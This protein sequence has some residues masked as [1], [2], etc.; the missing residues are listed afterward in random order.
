MTAAAQITAGGSVHE[1]TVD[2]L[3]KNL[4]LTVKINDTTFGQVGKH[5]MLVGGPTPVL[6]R[7]VN[8]K[9]TTFSF[10]KADVEDTVEEYKKDKV[11][12]LTD[13][14]KYL[15]SYQDL[16][17]EMIGWEEKLERVSSDLQR[18][19][20]AAETKAMAAAEKLK[21]ADKQEEAKKAATEAKDAAT[22]A[23]KV[24]TSQNGLATIV[25]NA[26]KAI[27]FMVNKC[28]VEVEAK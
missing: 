16:L 22:E 13:Y 3:V 24:A 10:A 4:K 5:E 12:L 2:E 9:K 28:G 21:K 20:D 23:L 17:I 11:I 27:N 19:I 1:G 26:K 8:D 25:V 15:K 18:E 6:I 7:E 14:L